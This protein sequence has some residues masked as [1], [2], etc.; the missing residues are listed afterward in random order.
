MITRQITTGDGRFGLFDNYARRRC[1]QRTLPVRFPCTCVTFVPVY[2]K[3]R[4]VPRQRH[5]RPVPV[6]RT[7]VASR[8]L[9]SS[10]SRSR[11]PVTARPVAPSLAVKRFVVGRTFSDK[12]APWRPDFVTTREVTPT[13]R[14]RG[15]R[16]NRRSPLTRYAPW[17]EWKIYT[18]NNT[19]S[20]NAVT[21]PGSRNCPR[22][23]KA[24]SGK[25]RALYRRK[26]IL[27][28]L[29]HNAHNDGVIVL[30]SQQWH[31]VSQ[32]FILKPCSQLQLNIMYYCI[33]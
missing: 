24:L 28:R 21:P 10:P 7:R 18:S 6:R 3:N 8:H 2:N 12:C 22:S 11:C 4:T 13:T 26:T 29:P 19:T 14:H 33:I 15:L 30:C 31:K 27:W 5:R 17:T 16:S 32:I 25:C 9:S 23:A 20:S 1:H